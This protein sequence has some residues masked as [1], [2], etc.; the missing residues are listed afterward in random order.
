MARRTMRH[1]L[2]D[3]LAGTICS[4][5]WLI[6]ADGCLVPPI[7]GAGLLLASLYEIA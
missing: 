5:G 4:I 7:F 6:L 1:T 2:K 3:C